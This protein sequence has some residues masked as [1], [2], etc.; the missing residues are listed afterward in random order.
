MKSC[1][2]EV[3][4]SKSEKKKAAVKLSELK[5]LF[6][7]VVDLIQSKPQDMQEAVAKAEEFLLWKAASGSG[8][9]PDAD[10]DRGVTLEEAF[11][12][13]AIVGIPTQQTVLRRPRRR[14]RKRRGTQHSTGSM[15]RQA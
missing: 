6:A 4:V 9:D 15:E 5:S 11:M 7:Q 12:R 8:L 10:L 1:E 3:C 13:R 14:L 2:G